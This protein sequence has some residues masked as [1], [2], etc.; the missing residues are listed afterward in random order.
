ML[1][2]IFTLLSLGQVCDSSYCQ[3]GL[4]SNPVYRSAPVYQ[5]YNSVPTYRTPVYAGS[6]IYHE[7]KC[8]E[9]IKTKTYITA[10]LT[11]G[12]RTQIPIVNGYLPEIRTKE[13]ADGT[14]HR[15]F[16]YNRQIP[17]EGGVPNYIPATQP[18]ADDCGPVYTKEPTQAKKTYPKPM[19]APTPT[20]EVEPI[21]EEAVQGSKIDLTEPEEKKTV[22]PTAPTP[23]PE[24]EPKTT[25]V[26]K[27]PSEVEGSNTKIGPSYE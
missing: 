16:I 27:R 4:Y 8:C 1:T 15:T 14:T 12:T 13:L 22:A 5:E 3:Q 10:V 23:S 11:N 25:S 18:L 6:P 21:P 2:A 9:P 26:M 19:K 17:Y 7:L 20:R 24:P